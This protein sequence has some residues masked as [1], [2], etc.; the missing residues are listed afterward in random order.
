MCNKNEI[1]ATVSDGTVLG[2]FNLLKLLQLN[3]IKTD[4]ESIHDRYKEPHFYTARTITPCIV[5]YIRDKD[6]IL[7]ISNDVFKRMNRIMK[8]EYKWVESCKNVEVKSSLCS[9]KIELNRTFKAKP[10]KQYVRLNKTGRSKSVNENI[11]SQNSEKFQEENNIRNLITPPIDNN[12]GITCE[13]KENKKPPKLHEY[14]EETQMKSYNQNNKE[15]PNELPL[16]GKEFKTLLP[17]DSLVDTPWLHHLSR[18]N[19]PWVSP[20][21]FN[22]KRPPVFIYLYLIFNYN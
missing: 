20:F 7:N 13:A 8:N 17:N 22:V 16:F 1:I 9:D 2:A 10:V 12:Y 21:M 11:L 14:I 19:L 6:F 4:Y 3:G 18:Y 15:K 5:G